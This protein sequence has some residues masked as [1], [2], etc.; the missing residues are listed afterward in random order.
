MR[1]ELPVAATLERQLEEQLQDVEPI[2]VP[3]NRVK[4]DG[5]DFLIERGALDDMEE[6]L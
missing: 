6:Y 1:D 5:S 3:P 2:R 4:F